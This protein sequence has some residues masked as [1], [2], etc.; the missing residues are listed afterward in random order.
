MGMEGALSRAEELLGPEGVGGLRRA[1]VMVVGV[2]GV[3]SWCSEALARSGVGRLTIVDGDVVCS[4]NMNR[5]SEAGRSTLG[6]PKVEALSSRLADVAP[7]CEVATVYSRYDAVMAE[8][9]PEL[10][11]L[12]QYDVVVDC[13]DSLADKVLLLH[14]GLL[15]G[16]VA[17]FSSMGA[18]GKRDPTRVRLTSLAEVQTCPLSRVLRKRLRHAAPSL[19]LERVMAAW[20]SELREGP[21]G[22]EGRAAPLGSLMTV[23]AAF[24]LAL[25]AGIIERLTEP[26]ER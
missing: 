3:G 5:Q 6:R 18:A 2:G 17:V 25:A 8:S 7:E 4:S 19:P 12:G 26:G 13:I 15:C 20:S 23:T 22:V 16:T 9:L 1:R 24:G 10:R 11:D 21:R 14:R